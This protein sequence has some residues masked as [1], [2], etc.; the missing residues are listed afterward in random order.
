[1]STI[2]FIDD[3]IRINELQEKE[4]KKVLASCGLTDI[5][6]KT[7]TLLECQENCF[8]NTGE[9]CRSPEADKLKNRLMK[10]KA[11]ILNTLPIG[12]VELVID[13][14]LDD[15]NPLGVFVAKYFLRAP[16]LIDYVKRGQLLITLTSQYINANIQKI[17]TGV[18]NEE[19]KRLIEYCHRPINN[20]NAIKEFD[21][22][23]SAFPG[24]FYKYKTGTP[25]IDALLLDETY[26]GNYIGLVCARILK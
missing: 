2:L 12:K 16:D 14:L 21:R 11:D 20:T 26:Y 6:V 24:F 13:V 3:E 10:I 7:E 19:E 9:L 18:L 8:D 1:M 23:K 5:M 17:T 15:V 22:D 25:L 4:M